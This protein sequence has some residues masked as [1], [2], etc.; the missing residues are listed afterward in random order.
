MDK[1]YEE[2]AQNTSEVGFFLVLLAFDLFVG[3]SK[4]VLMA[5]KKNEKRSGS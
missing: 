4:T 2:Y 3:P 5:V 1:K